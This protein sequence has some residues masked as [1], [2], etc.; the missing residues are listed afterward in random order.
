MDSV[1]I[2]S[3]SNHTYLKVTVGTK[4]QDEAATV[5]HAKTDSARET[6]YR[7]LLIPKEQNDKPK[8]SDFET[9]VQRGLSIL[10]AAY[11]NKIKD[12]DILSPEE[13]I[14]NAEKYGSF[15]AYQQAEW[16]PEK[17]SAR[18]T[19]F[20]LPRFEEWYGQGQNKKLSREDAVDEFAE[21]ITH[22]IQTGYDRAMDILG[23]IPDEVRAEL[24]KTLQ[25][26]H[27]QIETWKQQQ[28]NP[29]LALPATAS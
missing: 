23:D 8:K 1:N 6:L 24:E 11:A 5:K 21:M 22:S 19:G 27:E 16:S 20:A 2:L 13:H 4:K 29:D 12:Y 25:L 3:L 26:T 15:E 17:V 9:L 14:A 7:G 28:K 18:I 10:Q